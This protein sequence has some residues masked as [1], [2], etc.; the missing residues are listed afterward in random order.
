MGDLNLPYVDWNDI[1]GGNSGT[2]ALIK[3]LVW[4]NGYSQAIGRPTR[5][6]A[7]LEDF[8]VRTK[9]SVTSS[10]IVERVSDH[11][12][13][14]LEVEWEDTCIEPHVEWIV[15]VYKKRMS[16]A[17]KYFCAMNL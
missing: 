12:A 5:G 2:Q 14:T 4:E 9:S 13:V 15:P 7:L 6:D 11:E 8:L 17:Y 10:C 1:A 3:R 16:E